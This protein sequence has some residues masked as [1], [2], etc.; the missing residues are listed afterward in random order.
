[1]CVCVC[2]QEKDLC[3]WP[4][5]ISQIYTQHWEYWQGRADRRQRQT[6]RCMQH[7][8]TQTHCNGLQRVCIGCFSKCSVVYC[9]EGYQLGFFFFACQRVSHTPHLCAC[10][11]YTCYRERGNISACVVVSD[12][13]DRCCLSG[14]PGTSGL[15]NTGPAPIEMAYQ[16]RY[17]WK[18]SLPMQ[19]P[20]TF[21]Q[22]EKKSLSYSPRLPLF[23]LPPSPSA[24]YLC[25]V[26]EIC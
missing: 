26:L 21:C 13:W 8:S 9:E 17:I 20:T 15:L 5:C 4:V 12:M 22:K 10:V 25:L 18:N 1:M 3:S 19:S 6:V 23:S 14:M 2:V 11:H 7:T 16:P 24:L